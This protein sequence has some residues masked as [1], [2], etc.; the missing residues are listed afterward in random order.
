MQYALKKGEYVE[1][2]H[3]LY[4]SQIVVLEAIN[5]FTLIFDSASYLQ[6]GSHTTDLHYICIKSSKRI[7]RIFKYKEFIKQIK[8]VCI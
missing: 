8:A 1:K 3:T 4:L 2:L 6:H 7:M 5:K